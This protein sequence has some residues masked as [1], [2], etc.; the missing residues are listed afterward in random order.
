M[1]KQLMCQYIQYI[2]DQLLQQL[3]YDIYFK[4][5]NPFE[6]MNMISIEGKTNF[7]E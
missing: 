5:N 3:G 1:N 6:F 7:F 4:K 2:A